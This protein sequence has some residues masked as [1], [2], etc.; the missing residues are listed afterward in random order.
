MCIFPSPRHLAA[1][2]SL[3][4]LLHLKGLFGSLR[5]VSLYQVMSEMLKNTLYWRVLHVEKQRRAY[6][7]NKLCENLAVIQ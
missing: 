2:L 1:L 5:D 3:P 6:L 7:S 4:L